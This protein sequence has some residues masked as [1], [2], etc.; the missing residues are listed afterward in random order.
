MEARFEF[1][2]VADEVFDLVLNT[3]QLN[4]I[5]CRI[6]DRL[7]ENGA[8]LLIWHLNFIL[9]I[10][11]LTLISFCFQLRI[12]FGVFYFFM[13]MVR[14]FCSDIVCRVWLGCTNILEV[15]L[16]VIDLFTKL[17]TVLILAYK[18]VLLDSFNLSVRTFWKGIFLESFIKPI[19]R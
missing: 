7:F 6:N 15:S 19:S 5:S 9:N 17:N 8:S 4:R 16:I 2:K 14:S 13:F 11:N 12:Y 10:W 3:V 1:R 18:E